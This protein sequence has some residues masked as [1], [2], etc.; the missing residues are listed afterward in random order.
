MSGQLESR[1]YFRVG[2]TVR[3]IDGRTGTV[4]EALTLFASI[5]WAD[6]G[7]VEVE[8]FDESVVVEQRME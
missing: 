6:G 8:Q 7:R 5:E 4:V 1:H 2:D 3:S